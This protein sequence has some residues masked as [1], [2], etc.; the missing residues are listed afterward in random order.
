MTFRNFAGLIAALVV[1]TAV[2]AT[3]A[4]AGGSRRTSDSSRVS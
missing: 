4:L 3:S 2:L 1:S